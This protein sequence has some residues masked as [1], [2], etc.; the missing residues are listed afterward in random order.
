MFLHDRRHFVR[1]PPK[2]LIGEDFSF[3]IR[4]LEQL[5]LQ[6]CPSR[7]S[8]ALNAGAHLDAYL[9]IPLKSGAPAV[10]H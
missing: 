2:R 1:E 5:P 6:S 8:L 10:W 4:R 7:Y 9:S 3:N